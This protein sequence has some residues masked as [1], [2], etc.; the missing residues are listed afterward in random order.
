MVSVFLWEQGR[1]RRFLKLIAAN[2]KGGYP[3]YF[4]AAME[5]P[6]EKIMPLW[7]DYLLDVERQRA[8]IL[9]LPTSTVSDTEREFRSFAKLH[10][11]STEQI[12]QRD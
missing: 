10:G 12:R 7:Q 2:D 5:L 4:E 9:T 6:L 11:I 3:S 8:A 1:F